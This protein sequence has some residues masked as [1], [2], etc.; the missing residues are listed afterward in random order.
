MIPEFK[1][2]VFTEAHGGFSISDQRIHTQNAQL[3][4]KTATLDG[5]GWIDF[6]KNLN[7]DITPTFS[8]IAILQSDSIKKKATSII[9]QTKGYINIQLTGTLDDPH[10]SVKKFP[11]KLIEETIGGT[12]GTLKEVIGSIVDEIF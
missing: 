4:S 7:F 1:A 8:E 3:I 6:N 10:F 12:A 9:T 5:K 11:I 2:L